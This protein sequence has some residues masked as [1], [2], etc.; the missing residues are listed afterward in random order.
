MALVTGFLPGGGIINDIKPKETFVSF[1]ICLLKY[2]SK[3]YLKENTFQNSVV[4]LFNFIKIVSK[5]FKDSQK[6]KLCI[7][8]NILVQHLHFW[9]CFIS[10]IVTKL[11]F[12]RGGTLI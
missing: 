10:H 5:K 12:R 2:S 9:K 8:P 3:K 11:L 1:D 7:D 4:L 6:I